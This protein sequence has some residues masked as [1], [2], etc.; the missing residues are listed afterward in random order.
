[1]FTLCANFRSALAAIVQLFDVEAGEDRMIVVGKRLTPSYVSVAGL[2]DQEPL[3]AGTLGDPHQ[4]PHPLQLESFELKQNL[5]RALALAR[6][7]YRLPLPAVPD[8]HRPRAVLAR[9]DHTLE[10]GVLLRVVLGVHRQ[11]LFRRI[12]RRPAWHRPRLENP[13]P[14]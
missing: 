1:P 9:R 12:R 6:I 3:L 5:S 14:L 8:D 10:I 7:A 13:V 2:L 4:R 11:P